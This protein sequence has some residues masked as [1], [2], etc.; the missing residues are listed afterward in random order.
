MLALVF[1]GWCRYL[2]GRADDGRAIELAADPFL[3]EAVDAARLTDRDPSAFFS[4]HRTFG[5]RLEH[6]ERLITTFTE[7]LRSLERVGALATLDDWTK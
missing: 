3:S 6:S 7:A 5:P 4:Y 2:L 1:A